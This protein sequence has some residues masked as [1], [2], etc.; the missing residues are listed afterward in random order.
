MKILRYV[1]MGVAVFGLTASLGYVVF[2]GEPG[3]SE[4]HAEELVE[5]EF[6]PD[7]R[8]AEPFSIEL[9]DGSPVSYDD[10]RGDVV[11]LDFWATWCTPCIAEIPVYNHLHADYQDRGVHLLGVTVQSGSAEDVAAFAEEHDI[12]YPLAMG[13]ADITDKYGPIWGFPTTLLISPDGKIVK[14]WQGIPP[15]KGGQLRYLIEELLA[16]KTAATD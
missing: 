4:M 9:L 11:V 2:R 12:E 15:T 5:T 1:L 3:H 7:P 10:L 16:Q 8:P 14:Q 13:D 6:D